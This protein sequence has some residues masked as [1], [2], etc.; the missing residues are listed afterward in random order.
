MYNAEMKLTKI[1]VDCTGKLTVLCGILDYSKTWP[2]LIV[3]E[4]R[5]FAF[6]HQ[7]TMPR[8]AVGHYGG[9]AVYL[10]LT[11]NNGGLNIAL[12]ANNGTQDT[13][14]FRS[15][16][17]RA[18]Q[19]WPRVIVYDGELYEYLRPTNASF[20]PDNVGNVHHA[21]YK[22][23]NHQLTYKDK[24]VMTT[25][26]TAKATPRKANSKKIPHTPAKPVKAAKQPKV[27]SAQK[28]A[29]GK[30]AVAKV[31]PAPKNTAATREA[32]KK[33][34][35]PAKPLPEK[36]AV[37]PEQKKAPKKTPK[38]PKP[39]FG[40]A[41]SITVDQLITFA[42]SDK[43]LNQSGKFVQIL[44]F[45]SSR[46]NFTVKLNAPVKVNNDLIV[47]VKLNSTDILL[48]DA[49][50]AKVFR[51]IDVANVTLKFKRI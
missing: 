8:D 44:Q 9:C 48:L 22:P 42:K 32:V 19:R 49:E 50:A 16:N 4:D 33:P 2:A 43:T 17:H 27:A 25:N 34:R 12:F 18:Y 6:V 23:L 20:R 37:K 39:V 1:G 31:K 40:I 29:A 7:D 14:E 13:V 28:T 5:T 46:K 10:P 36:G 24:A 11:D 26:T 35:N 3:H 41:K 15:I 21:V 38:Q 51:Q 30:A 45:E 47:S